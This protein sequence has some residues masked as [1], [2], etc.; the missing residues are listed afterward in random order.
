MLLILRRFPA[1]MLC[2]L[3]V[4]ASPLPTMAQEEDASTLEG[5]EEAAPDNAGPTQQAEPGDAPVP[6]T[7]DPAE[8]LVTTPPPQIFAPALGR[9]GFEVPGAHCRFLFTEAD[10]A[11]EPDKPAEATPAADSTNA[12]TD[13]LLADPGLMFFTER[14]YDSMVMIE[15]GYARI[16]ALLRELELVSRETKD[17]TETR[18]YRTLGG[19]PVTLTLTFTI[20][21]MTKL[22]T[23]VDGKALA[24]RNGASSEEEFTGVCQPDAANE[25]AKS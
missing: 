22:N 25:R 2:A 16:D 23:L 12:E 15:R 17:K 6:A 9:I 11:P 18:V 14:R 8:V 24:S 4:L 19:E 1:F 5:A 7:P 10:S 3:A 20:A 21:E 13:G